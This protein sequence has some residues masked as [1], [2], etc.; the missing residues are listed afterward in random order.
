M[1]CAPS[2]RC[3][4][5][6]PSAPSRASREGS[7]AT[8]EC[9]PS[10]RAPRVSPASPPTTNSTPFAHRRRRREKPRF[11]RRTGRRD[12]RWRRGKRA[13]FGLRHREATERGERAVRSSG[14]IVAPGRGA[15]ENG[16]R[17]DDAHRDALRRRRARAKGEGFFNVPRVRER[18][19]RRWTG[20]RG[21]LG[22]IRVAV[23]V[24]PAGD[25]S[26]I[27]ISFV[28]S[29]FFHSRILTRVVVTPRTPSRVSRKIVSERL[30]TTTTRSRL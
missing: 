8:R 16:R 6:P 28:L 15:R 29:H 9:P 2:L 12:V 14:E 22:K 3:S 5:A 1:V 25:F 20:G 18:H 13:Y 19:Q 11:H 23:T 17:R 21:A 24:A 27:S 7:R 30:A 26:S 4:R 10:S